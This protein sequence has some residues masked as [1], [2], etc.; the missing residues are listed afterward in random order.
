MKMRSIFLAAMLYAA[1]IHETKAQTTIPASQWTAGAMPDTTGNG[2]P[3]TT[4]LKQL[5]IP[6]ANLNPLTVTLGGPN[7]I[8]CNNPERFTGDGW[9]FQHSYTNATQGGVDYP[10]SG[11]TRIYMFHLNFT[12][13]GAAA[14]TYSFKER[15]Y[16]NAAGDKPLTGAAT[17]KAIGCRETGLPITSAPVQTALLQIQNL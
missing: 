2:T 16:T 9:L 17:G 12:N 10:L 7:L 1:L 3:T 15:N 13:P 8:V 4:N 6:N 14:V 5:V 11:T